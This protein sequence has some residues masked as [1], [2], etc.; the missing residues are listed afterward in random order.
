MYS[1]G[2]SRDSPLGFYDDEFDEYPVYYPDEGPYAHDN[3]VHSVEFVRR[4]SSESSLE[5]EKRF[6]EEQPEKKLLPL[7]ELC[8][9]FVGQNFPFGVVQLYPSRVPEDVQRRV[10]FWS[11]PTDE[12]KLLDYAKVMGG[13]TENDIQCARRTK[14][15]GMVQS[16]ESDVN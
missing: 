6:E 7:K 11:F 10:A 1:P 15:T 9:R 13:A 5:L 4:E 12:K 16:G 3:F 2:S 14:V 8:C